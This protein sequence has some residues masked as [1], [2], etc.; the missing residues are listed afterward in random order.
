MILGLEQI[1]RKAI[2]GS[3][4]FALV[5]VLKLYQPDYLILSAADPNLCDKNQSASGINFRREHQVHTLDHPE[6]KA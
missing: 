5:Q 1:K 3:T 4:K 2:R 6:K